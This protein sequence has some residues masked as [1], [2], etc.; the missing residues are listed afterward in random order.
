MQC[1]YSAYRGF[2]TVSH[3]IVSLSRPIYTQATYLDLALM[4]QS[5]LMNSGLPTVW[6][7]KSTSIP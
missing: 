2:I 6:N 4:D 3:S 5:Q 7:E 1:H